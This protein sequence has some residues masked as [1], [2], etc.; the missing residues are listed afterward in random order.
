MRV[1]SIRDAVF[2]LAHD[3]DGRLLISEPAICAG[4]AG[5][6]LID[7]LLGRRV[8][9][10]GGRLDV[11]DSAVTGDPE[12]DAALAAIAADTEPTGPRSWLAAGAYERVAET[13]ERAGVIRRTT[14]RRLGLLPA[15]RCMPANVEDLVRL[16]SRLRYGV[17]SSQPPDPATAALC[18]L[19]RVLRLHASLLLSMPS[20]ELLDAL[21]DKAMTADPTVLQ[22][23]TAV[24]SVVTAATYR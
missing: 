17:H 11:I 13:L 6:T 1:G 18:G 7:L 20:A 16:R 21:A 2:L 24:D 10:V 22:V 8:A 4:L 3:E 23:I 15:T 5:A 19:V 14:V 12:T 9:V